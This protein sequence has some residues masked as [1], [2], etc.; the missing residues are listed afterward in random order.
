M[1]QEQAQQVQ[2][3]R[4]GGL[5]WWQME[6]MAAPMHR[7][8]NSSYAPYTIICDEITSLLGSAPAGGPE[9]RRRAAARARRA[10]SSR[11]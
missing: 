4:A 11:R 3:Q 5:K 1:G 10:A 7:A 2:G 8:A 6:A 9:W